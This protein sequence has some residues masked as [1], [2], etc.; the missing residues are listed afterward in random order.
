MSSVDV[1]DENRV[2]CPRGT[3]HSNTSDI[4]DLEQPT[5]RP[6]I[7][8]Q[9]ENLPSKT[10][11]KGVKVCFQTPRRD[12]FTKRIVSPTNSVKMTT[13]DEDARSVGS[14]N[15]DMTIT[16]TQ[17]K[18]EHITQGS[19]RM[20]L[21][22]PGS[23]KNPSPKQPDSSTHEGPTNKCDSALDETLPFTCSAENSLVNNSAQVSSTDSSVITIKLPAVEQESRGGTPEQSSTMTMTPRG[24]E[25]EPG[26][27]DEDAALPS[28]GSY[29]FNLDD[30]D[31][32]DPFKSCSSQIQ[33]SPVPLKQK[34][35]SK[36]EMSI[37]P[38]DEDLPTATVNPL[39]CAEVA[40]SEM[41][42]VASTTEKQPN[43]LEF[44]SDSDQVKRK[45]QPKKSLPDKVPDVK[46]AAGDAA[47]K[48]ETS[49]DDQGSPCNVEKPMSNLAEPP[50]AS[51]LNFT[52]MFVPGTE[53]MVNNNFE[54]Q[55]D[56]LEQFGSSGFKESALRKQSLYLKFD[57]LL[58]E[59]PKKCGGGGPM[60]PLQ[61]SRPTFASRGETQLMAECASE[62]PTS[63]IHNSDLPTYPR[64]ASTAD[65]IDV[66]KYSQ[67]DMDATIARVQA[68]A[69]E[70]EQL[71]SDKYNQLQRDGQEMRKIVAEFELIIAKM[72]ADHE[73][74]REEFQTK[75]DK[76]LLEKDT[77]SSDLNDTERS[78][79]DVFRRLEKYKEILEG[80]K[81]NE[82]TLKA[83]AQDYMVRLKKEEMRYQT[84]KAHAEEKI[85]QA[86]EVIA[87]V[88]S[89]KK[90]EISALNIQ[91]RREQMKVQSLEK[92]LDQK[93][94]EAEELTKLCDE[95]ISNAQ[96][97]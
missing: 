83:C 91:L 53:F 1:N 95:L 19:N 67:K 7:L 11:P 74:V 66:L 63:Q 96:N 55:I 51:L 48:I 6:S 71:M 5:G 97:G 65:I 15:S 45:S 35:E 90:A 27:F 43:N 44:D 12:P 39:S 57:P 52:E 9:T 88:R 13:M 22:P 42:T 50:E 3:K 82:E 38:T 75:L 4:F 36:Q 30:I 84:L 78:L 32:M 47:D 10:V 37:K 79:S 14:L 73:K 25:K 17:E 60:I 21:S 85:T 68:E 34:L 49:C 23:V 61:I 18:L 20:I 54:G 80:Y 77:V 24:D 8:R 69:K 89:K 76:V 64:L 70:K 59:S 40:V 94:K 62:A 29:D 2:L 26:A 92:N 28:K 93:V 41:L 81:K 33:N 72:T 31:T 16:L 87:E 58:K 46:L 56:Y 86:N